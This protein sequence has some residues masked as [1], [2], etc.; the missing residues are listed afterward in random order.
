MVKLYGN[1]MGSDSIMSHE[2]FLTLGREK[3][4]HK[5]A[6]GHFVS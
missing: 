5:N 6:G 2:G 3:S 4:L 1:Y